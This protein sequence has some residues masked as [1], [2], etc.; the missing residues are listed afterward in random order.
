MFRGYSMEEG[1]VT[2]LPQAVEGRL[3]SAVLGRELWVVAG[4]LRLI[5]PLTGAP[6]PL[7]AEEHARAEAAQ[8]R[9]EE[10]RARANAEMAARMAAEAEVARLR[11]ELARLRPEMP[12]Q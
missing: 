10:E 6:Y 3:V 12:P 7:P 9:A 4:W 2:A 5:D 1:R 11:A 8:L